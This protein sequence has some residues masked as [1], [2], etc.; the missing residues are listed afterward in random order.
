MNILAIGTAMTALGGYPQPPKFWM[1]AS[2][3]KWFQ[4]MSVFI[5]VHQSG[6]T[7]IMAS[8]LVALMFMTVI[9]ILRQWEE[10][11]QYY[12]PKYFDGEYDTNNKM[13]KRQ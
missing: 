3:Q 1:E 2:S 11:E 5:L 6:H 10:S 7:S 8:L 9:Y 12:N 4:Y 13:P